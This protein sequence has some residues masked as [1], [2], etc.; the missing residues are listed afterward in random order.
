MRKKYGSKKALSFA[1][2][3]RP[4]SGTRYLAPR[5]S[6]LVGTGP[7]NWRDELSYASCLHSD[8]K[9]LAVLNKMVISVV[10]SPWLHSYLHFT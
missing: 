9:T 2:C 3:S 7:R 6:A 10:D 1:R 8:F 4:Y 5:V